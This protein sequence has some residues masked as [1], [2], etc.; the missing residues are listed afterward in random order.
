[1]SLCL[2]EAWVVVEGHQL[3]QEGVSLCGPKL[4]GFGG[5]GAC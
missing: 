3:P 5:H 1:M 2:E 4:T